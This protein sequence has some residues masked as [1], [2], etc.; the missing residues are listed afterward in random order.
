MLPLFEVAG[1][2][3]R[4]RLTQLE[5]GGIFAMSMAHVVEDGMRA[6]TAIMDLV[7]LMNG[8][9]VAPTHNDR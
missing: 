3:Y 6:A 5:D 7:E 9:E 8:K 1:S 4:M 2:L